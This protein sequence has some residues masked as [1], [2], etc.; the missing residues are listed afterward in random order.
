MQTRLLIAYLLIGLMVAA[1]AVL[2]RHFVIRRRNHRRTMRGH[3][4]R[5]RASTRR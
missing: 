5:K 1:A 2:A 4:S 3:G